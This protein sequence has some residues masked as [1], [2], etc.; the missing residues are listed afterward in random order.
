MKGSARDCS[1]LS[2]N[3]LNVVSTPDSPNSVLIYDK[4][5]VIYYCTDAETIYFNPDSSFMFNGLVNFTGTDLTEADTSNVTNMENMFVGDRSLTSL[6][7][8]SW[9]VSNVENITA[10]FHN[11][12]GLLTLNLSNWNTPNLKYMNDMFNGA[13]SIHTI[14]ATTGF[15]RSSIIDDATMFEGATSL[16]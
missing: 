13:P 2:P 9:D 1:D 11:C 10:M 8:S 16:V 15:D 3:R 12:S 14:Y 4:T 7:L 5:N 6:D